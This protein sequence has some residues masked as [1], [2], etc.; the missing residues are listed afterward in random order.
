MSEKYPDSHVVEG[1]QVDAERMKT[2]SD[3]LRGTIAQDLHDPITGGFSGDNFL[4]I[5]FHG[6]YQQDDRD[7]RAE[8]VAQKLEPRHAM[9]LRCRL[10]GASLAQNSG[11]R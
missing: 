8:R 2:E 3:Y 5:R 7:I 11:R 9:M 1:K 4:L 6:M 10:P